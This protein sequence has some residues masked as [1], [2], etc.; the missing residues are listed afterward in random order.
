MTRHRIEWIAAIAVVS[1]AGAIFL[2]APAQLEII[3]LVSRRMDSICG[4]F[5]VLALATQTLRIRRPTPAAGGPRQSVPDCRDDFNLDALLL[6]TR[7]GGASISRK[8]DRVAK[9]ECR[10]GPPRPRPRVLLIG[11]RG[12][13]CPEP[14][15]P[16]ALPRW[17][18]IWPVRSSGSPSASGCHGFRTS[19]S[20]VTCGD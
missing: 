14:R 13:R 6:V 4:L 1:F 12:G 3:S 15:F 2:L 20:A 16:T 9:P 7:L 17:G 18:R 5:S 19:K 10:S 8:V 11:I